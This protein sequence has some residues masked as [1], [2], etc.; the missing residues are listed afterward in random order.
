LLKHYFQLFRI[1]N[2]F[3]VPSDILAGYFVASLFDIDIV[4]YH[5]ITFLVFSSIFL[6]I[7]GMVTNDLFD[8]NKDKIERPNRP[9]SSG[10]IKESIAISLSILFFGAGIL[11]TLLLTFTS[12][13]IAISLVVMILLYNFKFKDGFLRPFFMGGI[14]SLNIVYGASPNLEF[15]KIP[16]YGTDT[17]LVYNAFINLSILTAAIFVHVFTLTLLSKRETEVENKQFNKSLGL[18][19]IYRNYL[20]LFVILTFL[21]SL[22][23]PNKFLFLTF[24]ALFLA[25]S[26]MIFFKK[27]TKKNYGHVDIQFLVKSMLVLLI[28]LDAS[29]IAG[30][31]GLYM[32]LVSLSM[33]IPCMAIGK[34]VRMT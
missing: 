18:K 34:K 14:R 13:M 3:T 11:L 15:L 20:F 1:S 12:T 19:K 30:S 16:N 24:S 9:L 2:I 29:F 10:K 31:S 23:L 22:F 28:P 17:S 6:Y 25:P 33:I 26:T 8:I 32:G 5:S 21:G 7:G 27:A 4:S